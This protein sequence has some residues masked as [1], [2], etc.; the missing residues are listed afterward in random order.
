MLLSSKA[1]RGVKAPLFEDV[2]MA[3][4][5]LLWL[6][7]DYRQGRLEGNSDLRNSMEGGLKNEPCGADGFK[8]DW[9]GRQIDVA[10]HIKNGGNTRHPERCL[11][12][13][14]FWDEGSQRV[15]IASMPAHIRSDAT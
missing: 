12:I 3:A 8:F 10:W 15:V 6:A 7:N 4:R 5:C 13:Y 2:G 14:Y 1:R 11:R 9:Q